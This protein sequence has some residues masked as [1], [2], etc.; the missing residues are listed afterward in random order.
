LY[1]YPRAESNGGALINHPHIK[2][3]EAPLMQISSSFI[4]ENIRNKKDVRYMMPES[5]WD[6]IEEMHFYEK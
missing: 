6:Y 4:R 1:V 3:V 5:V 2:K